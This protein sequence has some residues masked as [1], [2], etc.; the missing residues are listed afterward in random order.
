MTAHSLV[1][2]RTKVAV[3]ANLALLVS[4]LVLALPGSAFACPFCIA[5]QSENVQKAF[6]LASLFLSVLPLAMIGALFLWL[7][8]RARQLAAEEAAGV[9]RLPSPSARPNRAA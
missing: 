6:A 9:I 7:R 1:A 4:A 8:R 2:A 5:A 3:R